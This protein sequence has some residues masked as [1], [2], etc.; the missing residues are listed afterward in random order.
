LTQKKIIFCE[1]YIKNGGNATQAAIQAGYSKKSAKQQGSRLLTNVDVSEYIAEKMEEIEY[2]EKRDIMSLKEIQKRRTQIAKGEITDSIGFAP[3]FGDQLKAMDALEKSLTIQEAKKE[4]EEAAKRALS[5]KRYHIDLDEIPDAFHAAIRDIRMHRHLEYVFEGGRGSTKSS[6]VA[7]MIPEILKNNRNMHAVALRKV[8]NTLKDSVYAKLKWAIKKQSMEDEWHIT[9]SPLQIKL[10]ATGQ[11][12]YF[13]GADDPDKIKSIAPEFGYIGVV[14]FEEL[15]QFDGPEEVRNITQS[16]IRGGDVAYIFK[17]FNPPKTQDSWVNE[18]T[19]EP[20]ANMLVHHS[21]YLDVP[22]EWLGKPFIDEANHLKETNPKAYDHEYLG[23]ATE[24]G[25]NVFSYLEFKDI[26]D[27]EIKTF[28]RIRNGTDWGWYPDPYAFVRLYYD[29]ARETI[30]LLDENYG[31]YLSNTTTAKW[32]RDKGYTDV[33]TTCDSAEKKSVTDYRDNGVPARAAIKGPGSVEYGMKW[34]CA[35]KI[36]I[37][38]KRTP[39]AYDEFKNYKYKRDKE[40]KVITGYPDENN[41]TI[42]AVRYALEDLY[43]R[44]GNSA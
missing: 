35:R 3:D 19:K 29:H 22:E 34:L 11:T 20:K 10:K 7:Q 42:D 36:V 6:T 14:W 40:G 37:D 30:Y 26:S 1:E 23:K 2:L 12:I 5:A 31:N 15:D 38:R 16:V 33:Y 25:A 8:G 21:T 28:D 39:N 13:R 18:Y 17:S 43:I 32:I 9:Q 4:K 44:R 41:H 24:K 27:E